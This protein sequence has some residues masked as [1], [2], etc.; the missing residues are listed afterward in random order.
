VDSLTMIFDASITGQA[1]NFKE[2]NTRQ[3]AKTASFDYIVAS[4][5]AW[6]NVGVSLGVLPL[7]NV[8][9]SYSTS[10]TV[11]QE[12]GK[13]TET[14]SGEG[15]L[16]EV[17]IG[18]GWHALKPLSVGFNAG[19][20]WGDLERSVLT[21]N[22]NF[23]SLM[24]NYSA[25]VKSYN[26]NVGMQWRQPLDKNNVVTLGATV[27]V[28]HKLNTDP[29]LD[30]INV[31]KS[32]TTSY[33]IS[34]GLEL[35]WTLAAGLTWQYRNRLIIAA[36]AEMQ[37]WGKTSYPL[38]AND[39]YT[40]AKDIMKDRLNWY[41]I[42]NKKYYLD[43][44]DPYKD[45]D[46]RTL[47]Q[48]I[49][50]EDFGK[51]DI[52]LTLS[53]IIHDLLIKSDLQERKIRLFDWSSLRFEEDMILGMATGDKKNQRYFFMDIHPDGS[54]DITEQK[55]DLLSPSI[56]RACIDIFRSQNS[57]KGNT[58]IEG[59]VMDSKGNINIIKDTQWVTIPEIFKI[60][61]ELESGNTKLRNE[62]KR[63]ELFND[64]L[65]IKQFIYNDEEHY[66]AGYIG[67]GIKPTL[68]C[69][70]HIR[71]F[72]KYQN[73]PSFLTKILPL[74]YV[75]FVRNN[76]LTVIPFPFKYLREHIN[77]L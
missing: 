34:N 77:S 7:S 60:R 61:C 38:Y 25:T 39:T 19:Y 1:T 41:L 23:G 8:G 17:F 48:H 55:I 51:S 74:M 2:G 4:F 49:T 11:N 37:Q 14:Y 66:F 62:E 58:E 32:D 22:S 73:A 42:H 65:D 44:S 33:K 64:I 59:I 16:H 24:K 47:I 36:D 29:T 68:Q 20:V 31:S 5:R 21:S 35:P 50:L 9:Y 53:A 6:R 15:G 56:Y 72:E 67:H 3:N 43:G 12:Y 30:V 27:G 75:T 18:F 13:L 40:A 10:S 54:F 52:P 69:A 63:T 28:G 45:Y 26:L 71:K 46:D 70:V 76:Q 57:S